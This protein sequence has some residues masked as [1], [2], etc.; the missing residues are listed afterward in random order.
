[1]RYNDEIHLIVRL[2]GVIFALLITFVIGINLFDGLNYETYLLATM[3]LTGAALQMIVNSYSM[4]KSFHDYKFN[5]PIH[6]W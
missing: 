5:I 1:M 4:L 3:L 6:S 2:L